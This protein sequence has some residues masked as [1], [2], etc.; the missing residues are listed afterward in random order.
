MPNLPLPFDSNEIEITD[1]VS[2]AQAV[3]LEARSCTRAARCPDCQQ[4]SC[5]IHSHY[6]RQPRDLAYFGQPVRLALTVPRFRCLNS[7][8]PR[9]TFAERFPKVL[10][11]YAHCTTRFRTTLRAV[12]F[13]AGAE[14]GARLLAQVGIVTS[15]DTLLRVIRQTSLREPAEP[16][17]VG[18]DDWAWKKGLRYGTLIVDLERHAP[19]ALLPDRQV[20]TVKQW[21]VQHPSV[22][23]VSRDR[24]QEYAQAITSGAPQALEVADRWHLLK[25]LTDVL[26]KVLERYATQLRQLLVRPTPAILAPERDKVEGSAAQQEIR[27]QRHMTRQA[28]FQH[29]HQLHQLGWQNKAIARH[30]GICPRTVQ[31]YLAKETLP[32]LHRQRHSNLDTHKPYLVQRWNEGCHNARQLGDE[33]RL[34]GYMGGMTSVRAYVARLRRTHTALASSVAASLPQNRLTRPL[35]PRRAAFLLLNS[36]ADNEDNDPTAFLSQLYARIPQLQPTVTLFRDFATLVRE[37]CASAFDEWLRAVQGS[38]CVA[39]R[40][41]AQGLQRDAA[42]VRAALEFE[43]SNGQ[44]EGQVN[45]LKLLKR[46]MYGRAKFDLLRL[47]VLHTP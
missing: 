47:R 45:R 5:S 25:N 32:R 23:I 33:I 18:I 30:L 6:S 31:R 46:Q 42:A 4:L 9:R 3:R 43:W 16:R 37:Q 22:A 34:Q 10:P 12:A 24:S 40:H 11:F 35:T 21:L 15:G 17:V 26:Y 19:I 28:R 20:E 1:V 7:N 41:F 2:T 27:Q 38:E 39:L 13:E 44:T 29:V 8:C 36:S 14:A